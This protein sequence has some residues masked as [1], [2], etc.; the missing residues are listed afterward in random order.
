MRLMT[1]NCRGMDSGKQSKLATYLTTKSVDLAILQEGDSG[2]HNAESEQTGEGVYSTLLFDRSSTA[3]DL[4]AAASSSD[5]GLAPSSGVSRAGYYNITG[6]LAFT[7]VT[8]V[9]SVDYLK[10]AEIKK[11]ILTPAQA[12]VDGKR[13]DGKKLSVRRG[14]LEGGGDKNWKAL[15]DEQMLVPVQRRMNMLGHRR[16]KAI[17]VTYSGK[18]LRIYYWHAPLGQD[19]KLNN[20]GFGAFNALAGEGC[21]GELAVAASLLFS[22]H[23]GITA[24]FPADTI[25]V[26]DL[27]IKSD[28][29]KSIYK[30]N[31]VLSSADGW[32]HAI[33]GSA[34][35]LTAEVTDLSTVAGALGDSDHSPIV[36]T[37]P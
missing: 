35:A 28:A 24:D 17:D 19:T 18:S 22:K 23:L 2:F 27:N 26:G 37:L 15:V 6:T 31:N 9:S 32:C 13:I 5:F 25:L 29:V 34:L 30:T 3:L 16:P 10:N 20:V 7:G 14:K 12:C 36:F 33:A 1:W 11:W 21:G 4:V 8:D